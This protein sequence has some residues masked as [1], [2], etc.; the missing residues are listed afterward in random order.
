ME[1]DMTREVPAELQ[2]FMNHIYELKKG[3]RY[4]ALLTMGCQYRDFAVRRLENN[5]ISYL[6][7]E[8]S[9]R[10]INLFFG[11]AECMDVI[12]R[13]VIRP[14][15]KLSAEEDFII[16]AMLG[17]D[18]CQQCVRFCDRKPSAETA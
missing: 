9:E 2:I 7:Q 8:V 17:Y 3:V 13:I 16:G 5:G 12:R 10:K 11:K 18:I 1:D 6:V 14:L 15:N 4:M